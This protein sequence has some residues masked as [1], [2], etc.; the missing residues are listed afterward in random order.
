MTFEW[1]RAHSIVLCHD[2]VFIWIL[3]DNQYNINFFISTIC[4]GYY[5]VN[6]YLHLSFDSYYSIFH[7]LL[8]NVCIP[9]NFPYIHFPFTF[10]I[11]LNGLCDS[12]GILSE[13][14]FSLYPRVDM[15]MPWSFFWST[16]DK[17]WVFNPPTLRRMHANMNEPTHRHIMVISTSLCHDVEYYFN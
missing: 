12:H 1:N 11:I 7:Y 5:E 3:E 15:S 2:F 13:T 4:Y 10:E 16:L 17:P 8:I 6:A 14:F 9:E